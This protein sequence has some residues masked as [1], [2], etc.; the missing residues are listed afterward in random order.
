MNVLP[1]R[2]EI[3]GVHENAKDQ[4]IKKAYRTLANIHHP[5]KGGTKE[6]FQVINE[7]YQ[8][9]SSNRSEYDLMLMQYRQAEAQ[10]A[11]RKKRETE[12]TQNRTYQQSTNNLGRN[13]GAGLFGLGLLIVIIFL[14]S[15]KE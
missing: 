5:D 14:F 2:Y 6:K 1:N 3:L 4:E 7:A 8:I 12:N 13:V 15:S 11:E 9:L 10:E